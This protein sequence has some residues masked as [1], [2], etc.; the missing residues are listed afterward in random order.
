MCAVKIGIVGGEPFIS[1]RFI[2]VESS[3]ILITSRPI[4]FTMGNVDSFEEACR[5]VANSIFGEQGDSRPTQEPR[6]RRS[7][8]VAL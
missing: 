2:N 1:A 4:R 7:S 8:Y 6:P 5:L 3:D